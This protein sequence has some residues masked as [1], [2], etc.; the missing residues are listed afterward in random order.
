MHIKEAEI[1]PAIQVQS[2]DQ[3]CEFCLELDNP[4]R[5]RFG[6]I[7]SSEISSRIIHKT[8]QFVVLPT[9][10]QLF[11]GSLLILPKEHVETVACLDDDSIGSLVALIDTFCL[12]VSR[13]GLPVVFEHG[14]HCDTGHACG[15]YHAHVHLVPVPSSASCNELL[16]RE[17]QLALNL[18]EAW[19]QL[20]NSRQYMLI[21]D[22]HRCSG[23]VSLNQISGAEYPSQ[24]MRRRLVQHFNLNKHWDWRSYQSIEPWL[25]G[26]IKDYEM[27]RISRAQ[28]NG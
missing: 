23:Y 24:Y 2:P 3:H 22:T 4:T 25:I 17:Y 8:E 9:L 15:I 12:K 5:S 26:T 1:G 27:D 20:R 7:Y 28:T 13:Y 19:R 14:A 6:H 10:G 21:R 11:K 18:E 16:E